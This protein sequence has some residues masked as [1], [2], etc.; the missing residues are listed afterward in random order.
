MMT[1]KLSRTLTRLGNLPGAFVWALEHRI[2]SGH[3]PCSYKAFQ[4]QGHTSCSN[5]SRPSDTPNPRIGSPD[6]DAVLADGTFYNLHTCQSLCLLPPIKNFLASSMRCRAQSWF[7]SSAIR[8]TLR[9]R[10]PTT[11]VT[12]RLSHHD[13]A[14]PRNAGERTRGP[15]YYRRLSHSDLSQPYLNL[16][17]NIR[18]LLV[19]YL[20][21]FDA[22]PNVWRLRYEDIIGADGGCDIERQLQTIWQLQLALHVPG[23]PDDYRDRIFSRESLTFRRGQI[24]DYLVDFTTD[25]HELFQRSAG[26]LVSTF[27]YGARW[28]ITRAFTV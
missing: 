15:G 25:H 5:A 27:G 1:A 2:I 24:G 14:V 21:W 23:R 7:L 19:T 18:E 11:C 13:V 9:Y 4:N 12:D 3:G 22:F 28:R 20:A 26:D 10:W 6:F 8:V 16:S 17:G